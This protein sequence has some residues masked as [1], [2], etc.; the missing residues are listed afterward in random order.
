[1]DCRI[2]P[3]ERQTEM[4]IRMKASLGWWMIAL[5]SL[6]SSAAAASDSRLAEAAAK[7]DREAMRSLLSQ[8]ADVNA[9]QSDGATPLAWASY[10]DDL[11]TA[12]LLIRAGAN[13]NAANIYGVTPLSLA[14]ANG[15]AAM[16]E[17]LLE[18]KAD[19]NAAGGNSESALMTCART[20]NLESVRSLLAHGANVNGKESR[21]GQTALMWAVAEKHPDVARLLIERGADVH[22]RSNS[23]FTPLLFAAQQGDLE[24]ARSLLAAGANVNE[25]TP[26]DGNALVV[27]SASGHQALSLFL[28]EKGADPNVADG[29]GLT[30]LHYAFLKGFATVTS[31]KPY[32]LTTYLF[33]P[34]M[35]ELAKAL[36]AHGANPNARI[37]KNFQMFHSV[38]ECGIN[39]AGATPFLLAAAVG[40]IGAMRILAAAGADPKLATVESTTPMMAAAG[41]GRVVDPNEEEK[42]GALEAVKLALELG[43]DV[44][45]ANEKRRT[46]LHVAA[47]TGNDALVQF[48]AEKGTKLDAKD[49]I[50]Q[51]PWTIA[52]H[53]MPD[54]AI[55]AEKI[56]PAHPS[57]AELLLKLGATKLTADDFPPPSTL[58]EK[59]PEVAPVSPVSATRP[60]ATK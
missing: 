25:A 43:N 10:R 14:C 42:K 29:N 17:K 50:G 18:A 23:G 54:A 26:Q 60:A 41:I 4:V 21:R 56:H 16:I 49:F 6:A 5:L 8:H 44:N 55:S 3:Q 52:E 2:S 12:D 24:T 46:A 40:D 36:L 28:L 32:Y 53:I 47:Y 48:L 22:A 34:N 51:T 59:R 13:V 33:R 38:C 31:V 19:A 39:P 11:E 35:L 20:G 7:G 1:M 45:A 58:A 15:N 30:A 57:T 37:A 27:A 9:P